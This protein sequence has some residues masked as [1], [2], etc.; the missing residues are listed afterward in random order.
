[1]KQYSFLIESIESNN[2]YNDALKIF[3]DLSEEDKWKL[4]PWHGKYKN[5]PVLYR[6][7]IKDQGFVDVYPHNHSK[8]IG[9]ILIATSN[10][11]RG[12]GVTHKLMNQCIKDCK[13]IGIKKI[14]WVCS[15]KNESSKHA[16]LKNGFKL[17]KKGK[18]E[19]RLYKEL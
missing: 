3:N 8:T 19:I 13:K 4:C 1:M 15:N 16:A 6:H 2:S 10:K 14:L 11:Y 9:F 12:K 18:T 7:V 17:Q 5:V